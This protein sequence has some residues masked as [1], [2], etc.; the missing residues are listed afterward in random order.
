MRLRL[1]IPVAGADV[2]AGIYDFAHVTIIGKDGRIIKGY[3]DEIEVDQAT[4]IAD[5]RYRPE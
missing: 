3:F 5:G 1:D 4:G 2:A